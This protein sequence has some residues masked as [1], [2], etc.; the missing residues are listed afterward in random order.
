MFRFL[1][2]NFLFFFPLLV[3][4]NET[5]KPVHIPER[6]SVEAEA[7]KKE[8]GKLSWLSISLG[9]FFR[10]QT[11]KRGAQ[12]WAGPSASAG[13]TA[14]FFKVIQ[15]R[16]PSLTYSP[17]S[18]Q[19]PHQFEWSVQLF[20]DDEPFGA[21]DGAEE[22]YRNQ[23]PETWESVIRYQYAFGYRNKF[24]LGAQ[25]LRDLDETESLLGSF[26]FQVPVYMFT[27]LSY[28]LGMA[29]QAQAK[30]L[31]GPEA[32]SGPAY[33]KATLSFVWPFLPWQGIVINRL[34]WSSLLQGQNRQADYV[35]GK[36]EH[37]TYSV[38]AVWNAF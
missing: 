28:E 13:P 35:R 38:L 22:D 20:N 23:R 9:A 15:L 33:H 2:L 7:K 8:E 6:E 4:G 29:E 14:T 17:F 25:L 3:W 16:G 18:R 1:V 27:S 30:Y 36:H 21:L 12:L 10:T 37:F 32:Q 31:Y 11:V 24:R 26:L 19:S 34:E 5:V